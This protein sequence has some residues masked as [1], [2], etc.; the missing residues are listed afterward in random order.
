MFAVYGERAASL[1][2]EGDLS[3]VDGLGTEMAGGRLVIEGSVGQEVGRQMTGGTLTVQ[4]SAGDRAGLAMRGGTLRISGDAGSGLGGSL[5][6]ASAGMTGG[7]I[8][9]GGHAGSDAAVLVRRGLVVVGGDA[10][11]GAGRAMIAGTLLVLGRI[12]GSVG[13]WNKRGSIIAVTG[14]SIPATYRY[15]CT[16]QPQYLRLLCRHLRACDFP[17]DDWVDASP[18]ARH[19]GDLSQLGRGEILVRVSQ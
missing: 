4:G 13:E 19:C 8:L 15:A 5:P 1:E 2:M 17:V 16:Y 7:E 6:G 11:T 12:A 10:G 9:V 18:Y 14:A 3:T